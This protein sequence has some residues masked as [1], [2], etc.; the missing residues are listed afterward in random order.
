MAIPFT[1][2][3]FDSSN[4][5]F[6]WANCMVDPV[7]YLLICDVRCIRYVEESSLASH[8]HSWYSTL[9]VGC[10]CPGFSGTFF[11]DDCT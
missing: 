3:S 8:L 10:E 5:V 6:V 2:P 1:F 4:Q 9:K 11:T 7:A